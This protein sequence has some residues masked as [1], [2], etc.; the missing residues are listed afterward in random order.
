MSNSVFK[1]VQAF[2]FKRVKKL[3]LLEF[4]LI[5]FVKVSFSIFISLL[6]S[7]SLLASKYKSIFSFSVNQSKNK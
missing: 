3:I 6:Y 4:I 1:T 5:G 2:C 7:V